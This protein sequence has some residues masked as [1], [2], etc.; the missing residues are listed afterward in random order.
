MGG[1][2]EGGAGPGSTPLVGRGGAPAA[3]AA[4]ALGASGRSPPP[5]PVSQMQVLAQ[6]LAVKARWTHRVHS[7]PGGGPT[8]REAQRLLRTKT[9]GKEHL[10]TWTMHTRARAKPELDVPDNSA[11]KESNELSG[12]ALLQTLRQQRGP[13]K[14]GSQGRRQAGGFVLGDVSVAHIKSTLERIQDFLPW[15]EAAAADEGKRAFSAAEVRGCRDLLAPEL[16]LTVSPAG[17]VGPPEA[18]AALRL[19]FRHL[20]EAPAP[21]EL[22]SGAGCAYLRQL[23]R[24]SQALS[25]GEVFTRSASLQDS[26]DTELSL[27]EYFY[28]EATGKRPK[29]AV[30]HIPGTQM[31]LGQGPNGAYQHAD[32]VSPDAV[33]R[34]ELPL[35]DSLNWSNIIL[36]E[37]SQEFEEPSEKQGAA[38]TIPRPLRFPQTIIREVLYDGHDIN[39]WSSSLIKR[40]LEVAGFVSMV[41][42]LDIGLIVANG[43][44]RAYD[45]FNM[46]TMKAVEGP[47]LGDNMARDNFVVDKERES[48]AKSK[49]RDF[50]NYFGDPDGD[51]G[52]KWDPV[53]GDPAALRAQ[54]LSYTIT[55]RREA[56]LVAGHK[57]S[58][59][60]VEFAWRPPAHLGCCFLPFPSSKRASF[61]TKVIHV[62]SF[63]MMPA[64]LGPAQ[65]HML[66]REIVQLHPAEGIFLHCAGGVGR[67]GD[68]ALALSNILTTAQAP[69]IK[70]SDPRGKLRWLRK[71]R[72]GV[73]QTPEQMVDGVVLGT[74]LLTLLLL[75]LLNPAGCEKIVADVAKAQGPAGDGAAAPT[76]AKALLALIDRVHEEAEAA[77]LI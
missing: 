24:A 50:F 15:V 32:V 48:Y 21:P 14:Y 31:L 62:E 4:E 17:E 8:Q 1:G 45:M 9:M 5:G 53:A 54:V 33:H 35:S 56:S 71:Y 67:T 63:D 61:T 75:E 55:S 73:V 59:Y 37:G 70:V 20:R 6:V 51:D 34:L 13:G 36:D 2:R 47:Y 68:F 58:K 27:R 7:E 65:A 28:G 74:Q 18:D 12:W 39:Y 64:C 57:V 49:F 72:E 76:P 22:A 11:V 52:I 16:G 10:R 3:A 42:D 77:G 29:C 25:A 43:Y 44:T 66:A 26:G 69:E 19:G 30:S 60:S 23:V 40:D 46:K 41:I 38:H